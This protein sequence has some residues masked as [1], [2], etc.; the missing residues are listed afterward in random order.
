MEE[1]VAADEKRAAELGVRLTPTIFVNGNSVTGPSLTPNGIRAA[2]D[3][4]LKQT[5]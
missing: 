2:I 4:A 5:P 1:R 3:A